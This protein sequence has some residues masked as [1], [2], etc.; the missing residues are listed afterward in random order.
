M[1]EYEVGFIIGRA[2]SIAATLFVSYS[3]FSLIMEGVQNA[4]RRRKK[5]VK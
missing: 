3:V 5:V 1:S 4:K 2:V